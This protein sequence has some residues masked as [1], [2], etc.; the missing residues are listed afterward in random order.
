MKITKAEK[1]LAK[2]E[3]ARKR[4]SIKK[5]KHNF[6]ISS[7]DLQADRSF[8]TQVIEAFRESQDRVISMALIHEETRIQRR[9]LIH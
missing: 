6:A 2:I 3:D 9:K 1:L 7:L 5:I 8:R 4:K